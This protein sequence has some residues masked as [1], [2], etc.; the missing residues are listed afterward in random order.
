M[1]GLQEYRKNYVL[2]KVR[3]T[4]TNVLLDSTCPYDDGAIVLV[5]AVCVNFN[6]IKMVTLVIERNADLD[7][8]A[9]IINERIAWAFASE[10]LRY[11]Q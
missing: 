6:T 1:N 4:W 11:V 3:E 7:Q 2:Q 10:H 9:E 5:F 8:S